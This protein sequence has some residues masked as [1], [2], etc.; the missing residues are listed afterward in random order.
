MR[1]TA[2]ASGGRDWNME[3]TDGNRITLAPAVRAVTALSQA[4]DSAKD[5]I[6][7]RINAL[8]TLEPTIIRHQGEDRIAVQVP[9]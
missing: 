7:R 6:D 8:G 5:V 9:G 2:G 3:F 4:M 1:E